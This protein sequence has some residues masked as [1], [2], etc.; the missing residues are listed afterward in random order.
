MDNREKLLN[1][2][3]KLFASEGYSS[4][5]IQKI[6]SAAN[7]TKPTLYHYFGNKEGLLKAL[8]EDK[9]KPFLK[10]L[11]VATNYQGDLVSTLEKTVSSY[12]EFTQEEPDFFRMIISL[13]VGPRENAAVKATINYI[14][15]QYNLL[16]NLFESA[17]NDHGNIKGKEELLAICFYGTVTSTAAF[18]LQTGKPLN[19]ETMQNVCKQFMH[20]IFC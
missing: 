11:A 6:V 7:V 5:G 19:D 16:K 18:F 4:I 20:G 3:L 8:F 12:F 14:Q 2:A 1:V 15:E 13:S 17:I 10:K 9:I